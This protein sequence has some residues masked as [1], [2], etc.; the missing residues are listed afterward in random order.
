MLVSISF[1]VIRSRVFT[2]DTGKQI[3]I[4]NGGFR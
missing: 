4:K 3:G 1:T 2:G